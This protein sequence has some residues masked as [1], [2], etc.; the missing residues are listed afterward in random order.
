M[1]YFDDSEC[2]C[3]PIDEIDFCTC[4]K[5]TFKTNSRHN[6]LMHFKFWL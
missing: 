3:V 5:M 2:F 4:R 1:L 6:L